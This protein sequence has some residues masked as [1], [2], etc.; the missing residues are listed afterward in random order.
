MQF[1]DL[2]DFFSLFE[3]EQGRKIVDYRKEKCLLCIAHCASKNDVLTF[4]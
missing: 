1:L 4:T 2:R 3:K